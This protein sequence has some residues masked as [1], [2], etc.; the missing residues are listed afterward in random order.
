MSKEIKYFLHDV[1]FYRLL[2]ILKTLIP[3][4]MKNDAMKLE[5]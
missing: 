2:L 5:V 3:A 1:S 4:I